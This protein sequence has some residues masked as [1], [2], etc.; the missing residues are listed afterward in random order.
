[1][2]ESRKIHLAIIITVIV[3]CVLMCFMLFLVNNTVVID[4]KEYKTYIPCDY[5]CVANEQ[6]A[7]N[8]TKLCSVEWVDLKCRNISDLSFVANIKG[9]KKIHIWTDHTIDWMAISSCH[10]LEEVGIFGRDFT[11]KNMFFLS[12]LPKLRKLY[13]GNSLLPDNGFLDVTIES[14]EGMD[15]L[16][17]LET[18]V[19]CNVSLNSVTLGN[20][21]DKLVEVE[22]MGSNIE[23]LSIGCNNVNSLTIEDCANLEKISINSN[24]NSLDHINVSKCPRLSEI[25][26]CVIK[27]EQYKNSF[28]SEELMIPFEEFKTD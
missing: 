4:G 11:I 19:M 26:S 7:V 6:D 16:S 13:L 21:M 12:S 23:E 5:I 3:F 17:E 8:A 9:L 27:I 24:N 18:I 28:E 25:N 15:H 1:M 2:K 20:E 10:N 14:L 22:I